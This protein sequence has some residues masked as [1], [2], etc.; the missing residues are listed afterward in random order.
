MG[1]EKIGFCKGG[2]KQSCPL[3]RVPLQFCKSPNQISVLKVDMN[4]ISFSCLNSV[5]SRKTLHELSEISVK[6]VQHVAGI[7]YSHALATAGS[8]I[9]T[10]LSIMDDHTKKKNNLTREKKIDQSSSLRCGDLKGLAFFPPQSRRQKEVLAQDTQPCVCL[11]LLINYEKLKR[12]KH[13]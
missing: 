11:K 1:V 13:F 8:Y 9:T 3:R 5:F 2:C 12:E 7:N 4:Q 10:G 6:H